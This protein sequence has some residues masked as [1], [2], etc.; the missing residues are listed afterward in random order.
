MKER[1]TLWRLKVL[2]LS[3]SVVRLPNILLTSFPETAR[4]K[5]GQVDRGHQGAQRLVGAD[6]GCGSFPADVLF[7]GR[8]GQNESPASFLVDSHSHKPSGQLPHILFARCKKTNVWAAETHRYAQ[9]LRFAGDDVAP[10]GGERIPRDNASHTF[11]IES[12]P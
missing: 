6:V 9:R 3:H 11:T 1:D 8:Q 7:A 10:E 5:R 2:N 4:P 12:A